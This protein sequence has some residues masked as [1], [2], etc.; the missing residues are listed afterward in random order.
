MGQE[1]CWRRICASTGNWELNG[2]GG[3][4]VERKADGRLVGTVT[5]FTAWRDFEP[6]FGEEP[7]MGWIMATETHGTGL[8]REACEA[9]LGWAEQEL[10]PTP[11]WAI[12]AEANE[13]SFRLAERLGFERVGEVAYGGPTV[14]LKRPPWR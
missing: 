1:E 4:A 8:A 3:L 2:F 11:I 13:P 7:E 5:L 9:L 12:I 14:V 6:V 10:E